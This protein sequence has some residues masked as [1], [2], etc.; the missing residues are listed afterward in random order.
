M[1]WAG[2]G[3]DRAVVDVTSPFGRVGQ[4]D[5]EGVAVVVFEVDLDGVTA[6]G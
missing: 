3:L 5:G 1:V 6:L 2:V 4:D